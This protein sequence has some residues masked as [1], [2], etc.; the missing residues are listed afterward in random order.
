MHFA[1]AALFVAL[2]AS[3]VLARVPLPRQILE[4]M[5]GAM[6]SVRTLAVTEKVV[7][8]GQAPQGQ[9]QAL[10]GKAAFDVPRAFR[11]DL[12]TA[13]GACRAYLSTVQG[14]VKSDGGREVPLD[15]FK[16]PLLYREPDLLMSRLAALGV[17]VTRSS[18]GM[19][20]GQIVYVIG[21]RYPDETVPQLWIGQDTRLPVRFI[22]RGYTAGPTAG[23]IKERL[24]PATLPETDA[25][26]ALAGVLP[27]VDKGV[28][29]LPS[30]PPPVEGEPG[31]EVRYLEW[32]QIGAGDWY[33]ARIQLLR[34]GAVTE[35]RVM[36]GY[37]LN[38]AFPEGY[39]DPARLGE[40]PPDE[41]ES[42]GEA[43]AP[44]PAFRGAEPDEATKTVEDFRKVFE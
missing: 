11:E 15:A 39:F 36:E 4:A 21:A 40:A 22:V 2:L 20:D 34:G 42:H 43:A 33:P 32:R 16:D 27:P 37:T 26:S 41:T 10:A 38:P 30:L 24:R 28:S 6:G 44:V 35:E 14:A 1:R 25:P 19:L 17:N 8:T 12:I 31:Q 13:T 5:Q 3:P 18:M 23:A 29:S 9:D 7:F